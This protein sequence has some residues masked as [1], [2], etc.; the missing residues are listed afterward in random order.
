[1]ITSYLGFLNLRKQAYTGKPASAMYYDEKKG[2]YVIMGEEESEDEEPPPPPPGAKKM[3]TDKKE[4]SK[5]T[6]SQMTGANSLTSVGFAG[7]LSNKGRGRGGRGARK[8]P[9]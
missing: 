9:V 6:E 8:P 5:E 3:G 2:R 4:D 1:M 7:A